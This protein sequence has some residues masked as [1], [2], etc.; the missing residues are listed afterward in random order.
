VADIRP[1]RGLR[2]DTDRVALADAVCP[3]YDV[4]TP[5]AAESLRRRSPFNAIH[6]ELPVAPTGDPAGRYAAAAGLLRDW[7][8]ERVVRADDEPTLYLVEQRFTGPDGRERTRSG[9]VARLRLEDFA[10]RVV[11]PHE[12]THAGPKV[13]RLE[14]LRATHANLSQ[15]FLLYPDSDNEIGRALAAAAPPPAAAL[16]AL[17]GD[18]NPCS[19]RP[20]TGPVVDRVVALFADKRVLIADGHHR[21]ETALAYRDERRAVGDQ[22]ADWVMVCLSNMDDP[23][24]AIF[25]THRLLKN[26]ALPPVD[27]VIDRLR[28]A[29][30]VAEQG[31]GC[32]PSDCAPAMERISRA[33]GADKALGLYFPRQR[34]CVTLELRDAAVAEAL[35]TRGL[36]SAQARLSVNLLAELVFRD[37]LGLDP[38]RLEGNLDFVKSVHDAVTEL[39]VG[40]YE[41]AAFLGATPMDEVRAVAERGETMPQKSTYFYPKLLTGLVFN[42][43]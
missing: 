39:E 12:K 7:R 36:S 35:T 23:G 15:I 29:F 1:F 41:V 6:V 9:F 2:Y 33:S 34:R 37:A 30:T 13:D 21:Y 42:A 22:S 4:I 31:A 19:L 38:D 8:G 3:P 10:A 40:D 14:L 27:E 43:L 28:P 11:L 5:A 24:L 32:A 18:G 16:E 20:V 17:V 25:A 26:V